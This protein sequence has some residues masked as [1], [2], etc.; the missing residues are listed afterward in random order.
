MSAGY[1]TPE[2]LWMYGEDDLAAPGGKFSDLLNKAQ[3]ALGNSIIRLVANALAADP[4][5]ANAAAVAVAAE[6]A[7]HNVIEANETFDPHYS[8]ALVD[9]DGRRTWLEANAA[10][11]P[12][13]RSAQQIV[14]STEVLMGEAIGIQA[15][16]T[17]VTRLS[18][19]I[20]DEDDRRTWI[21]ADEA[22]K[23]TKRALDMI[24]EGLD[25]TGAGVTMREFS[26]P[27]IACPG[28]SL[29]RGSGGEGTSYPG[30]LAGLTGRTVWNLG[31]G[32]ETSPT[33]AG[34]AGG[35]PWLATVAGSSIPA[36]GGV[37]VT[38][39]ADDGS[40]VNPLLQGSAGLNPVR[41]QGVEG[42]LS[43]AAGTY[44]FTRAAAGAAVSVRSPAPVIT[45]A[46]LDRRGDITVMWWGENDG[47]NDATQIIGRQRAT[48]E[49]LTVLHPR[50]LVIGLSTS[51]A[52]ARAPMEAQFL[53]E[54]GRRFINI[55]KYLSSTAAL[56]AGGISPSTQD[57]TDIGVGRVPD[58]LRS[59]ATH[60]N[61]AG[62][63]LVAGQV[64]ARLREMGWI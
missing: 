34:R 23:P 2:G 13:A 41:I 31:V 20:V 63:T 50:Y 4:T 25:L 27:D 55:R 37:T 9:E 3:R 33:I 49:A 6:L 40:A 17:A 32:G 61:A 1:E 15:Q 58:S 64:N 8:F 28:D 47:T 21:E 19:A 59:D 54:Y 11:Q 18:V 14:D 39:L 36:S 29:T 26:G 24:T 51:T 44:T 53:T 22:G 62:Y 10:G 30:V 35:R 16:D 46:A 52:A 7:R 56:T 57:T 42:T 60:L 48:I 5:P 43:L 38:L 12:T 45:A